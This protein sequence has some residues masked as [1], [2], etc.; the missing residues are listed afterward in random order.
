MKGEHKAMM[1]KKTTK[2]RGRAGETI[3]E[4]LIALLISSLALLILAGA[5]SAGSRIILKAKKVVTDY[6]AANEVIELQSGTAGGK[7]YAALT[8]EGNITVA[9]V[10]DGT[11]KDPVTL[12]YYLNDTLGGVSVISYAVE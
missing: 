6:Y 5:V 4:T 7:L 10:S 1:G 9:K 12:D 11:M 2:L 3:A 8:A